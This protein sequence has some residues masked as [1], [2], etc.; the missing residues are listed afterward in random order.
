MIESGIYKSLQSL[1]ELEVY[2]LLIPDTEQQGITYQRISDPEIESGL[3]RTSLVAGRFQISFV[4]VSDYSGLLALDAQL[5]QMWKGIRYGD[6]G[7]YPVQYVE[8]GSLQQDKFTLPNNAVQYR[9]TRDFII[10]F[11]E[12]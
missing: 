11:S 10:Y 12:V 1:S 6:I 2:P 3:V 5:W 9:L 4:K 7:G 8:R